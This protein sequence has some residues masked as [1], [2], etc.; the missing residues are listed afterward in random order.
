MNQSIYQN[1]RQELRQLMDKINCVDIKHLSELS[2]VSQWQLYRLQS[3]LIPR[4]PLETLARL[5]ATLEIPFQDFL[6]KFSDYTGNIGNFQE[7]FLSLEAAENLRAELRTAQENVTNLSWQYQQEKNSLEQKIQESQAVIDELRRIKQEQENKLQSIESH[8]NE[9]I[10]NLEY[11]LNQLNTRLDL[12]NSLLRER[13]SAYHN[14]QEAYARQREELTREFQSASIETLESW[15][16]QWP[17]AVAVARKNPQLSAVK[18]L[19]LV[20]PVIDLLERWGI[21]QIH[22]V[23]EEV[24]YDPQIHQLMEGDA[25][26]ISTVVVRYV[27]YRQ[28]EKLLYRAKVSQVKSPLSESAE[29]SESITAG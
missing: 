13:Q 27:G 18:L 10:K 5:A 28:S 7:E 14:L 11:Q 19:A 1:N 21:E 17:T 23:G 20:K 16:L 22:Q 9:A 12:A 24:V 29:R 15:L 3:G 8:E 25:D 4:L 26:N 2:G 6:T